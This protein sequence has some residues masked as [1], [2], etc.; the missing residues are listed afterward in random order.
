M[1]K[2]FLFI[3][4]AIAIFFCSAASAQTLKPAFE[5]YWQIE[6]NLKTPKHAVVFFYSA[7]HELMYKETI[8]GKRLNVNRPKIRRMLNEVLNEVAT[9]WQQERR[10]KENEFFVAKRF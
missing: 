9:A 6:S 2:S 7:N 3:Q 4:I 8:D 1:K 5:P 10:V